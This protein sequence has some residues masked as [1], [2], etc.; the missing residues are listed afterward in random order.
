MASITKI[1][2]NLFQVVDIQKDLKLKNL[3]FRMNYP[4]V[5][6]GGVSYLPKEGFYSLLLSP[7][8]HSIVFVRLVKN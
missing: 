2:L 3:W 8:I 7:K 4:L 6:S 1:F 5:D